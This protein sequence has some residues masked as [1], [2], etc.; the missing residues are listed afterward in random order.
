MLAALE[1]VNQ[2][3]IQS[4]YYTALSALLVHMNFNA[5]N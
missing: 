1:K 2:F 3:E 5:A 4:S